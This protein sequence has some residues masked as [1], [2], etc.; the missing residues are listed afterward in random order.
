MPTRRTLLVASTL[1]IFTGRLDPFRQRPGTRMY[2][3]IAKVVA[4]DHVHVDLVGQHRQSR[5]ASYLA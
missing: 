3:S 4:T 1:S 2:G 5:A